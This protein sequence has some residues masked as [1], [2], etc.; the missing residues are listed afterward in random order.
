MPL[1]GHLDLDGGGKLVDQT[2]YYSMI[3]GLLYLTAYRLD[4]VCVCARFQ[5][6]HK[7]YHLIVVKRILRYLNCTPNIGIWYHRGGS[8]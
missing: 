7:E 3:V 2:L 6:N 1:N 8:F 5:A 4:L